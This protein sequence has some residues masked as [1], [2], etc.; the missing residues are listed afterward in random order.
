[1]A[2]MIRRSQVRCLQCRRVLI[3]KEVHCMAVRRMMVCATCAI[4]NIAQ[5]RLIY[6]ANYA[7]VALGG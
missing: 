1:M 4:Y 2:A 6:R 3:R 5:E 7:P